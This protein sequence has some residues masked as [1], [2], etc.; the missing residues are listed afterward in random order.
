MSPCLHNLLVALRAM[1]MMEE[2]T[3]I[4]GTGDVFFQQI[5]SLASL[6]DARLRYYTDDRSRMIFDWVQQYRVIE[7]FYGH[8]IPIHLENSPFRE[9]EWAALER[10]AKEMTPY[11]MDDYLLD[12]IDVWILEAYALKGECEALPGDVVLDCGTYTG[13]TSLYF[14]KQV[15]ASGHVYG[16]EAASNTFEKYRHNMRGIDNVTPVHVAVSN[17]TGSLRFSGDTAGA[18][19]AEYGEEVPAI[20]LDDFCRSHSLSK[21]D[22]IKMDVEGAEDIALQ[23]AINT[24]QKYRP[25]MAISAYHKAFD[26]ISLPSLILSIAPYTF[27]LR[28]YSNCLWETVLYCIPCTTENVAYPAEQEV[29]PDQYNDL[30]FPLLSLLRNILRYQHAI[31]PFLARAAQGMQQLMEELTNL[32]KVHADLRKEF[33]D[34][35][36]E[37]IALRKL[38][39]RRSAKNN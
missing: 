23:G 32:N 10:Q 13:N 31:T 2:S 35:G 39:K 25:K 26:I 34:L 4:R 18:R 5:D 11:I 30:F 1:S 8:P 27:K 19:L 24:I 6:E 7:S 33:S 38:L 15:G 9:D 20:T 36:M 28:H 3:I 21:V 12:R 29:I 17:V 22:Y 37:N 14:S 16:F